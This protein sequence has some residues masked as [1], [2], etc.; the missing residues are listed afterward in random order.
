MYPLRLIVMGW[1]LTLVGLA[2]A[3]AE[4]VA[5]WLFD[6]PLDSPVAT[7]SSG[8][9]YHLTLGPDA[10]I[11]TGGQFGHAL[12]SDALRDQDGLGAFRYHAEE[13][14]N[15]GDRDWTLECWAKAR[16]DMKG[17]NRLWGLSGVNYIDYGRGDR[18]Q[19]LQVAS[20]FLPIDK[21]L[22]WDRPTGDL[23]ADGAFHHMAVVY[24]AMA[25]QLRHYFDGRLQFAVPGVWHAVDT[26][27]EPYRDV[28][29]PP[30][31]PMLQIGM[32]D[33]I[34]QWNHRELGEDTRLMKKFEG[35]LDE[36]RF[37]DEALYAADFTP[38][39]HFDQTCMRIW[40]ETLSLVVDEKGEIYGDTSLTLSYDQTS[41]LLSDISPE[42]IR[43]IKWETTSQ[44]I[45]LRRQARD[46]HS[47]AF[48]TTRLH[49]GLNLDE[50]DPG[51]HEG[52]IRINSK[53]FPN[54]PVDVSVIVRRL[55]SGDALDVR[56]R[57]Q[58]F[59][60]ERFI[61][62]SENVEL[63]VNPPQ[64]VEMVFE[65]WRDGPLV[66]CNIIHDAQRGVFRMYYVAFH[67][68]LS[69][70]YAES[71]DGLYWTAP[72]PDRKQVGIVSPD[73]PSRLLPLS[74]GLM[75]DP[76]DA[77]ERRYKVVQDVHDAEHP[78]RNGVYAY[79]SADGFQFKEAGRVLPILT[80]TGLYP[81]WDERIRKYVC[82]MRVM[83][84]KKGL[85]MIQGNQFFYRPGFTYES[86]EGLVDTIAPE[87]MVAE[88]Y[89]NIRSRARIET[90]DILKPWPFPQDV[91]DTVYTTPQHVPMVFHADKWDG[92]ADVYDGAPEI[93][94][95]AQD[96]YLM[97]VAMF[98]HFHPSR[99]PWF[100]R[101]ADA[102]GPIDV[103]LA[104]SRD[105]VHW[106]RWDRQPYVK[107]GMNDEWDRWLHFL[108]R[109]T[110]PIGNYLY[111]YYWTTGRLHDSLLL[112]PEVGEVSEGGPARHAIGALRQRLDGFISANADHRG[113]SLTTPPIKFSGD[114]LLL[115]HETAGMG[116]M[117]VEL[118]DPNDVPIPGY[119]LAD[120]EEITGNDVA[121]EVRWR[122]SGDVSGLAGRPLK[123]H[124]RMVSAKLYAFQFTPQTG[125]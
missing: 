9:G 100:Y 84:T 4:T 93:Y 53:G 108:G 89:E 40:P 64:K 109:G 23:Q 25:R 121:W 81:F 49:I 15:P 117:F 7:D 91:P 39:T 88:G 54:S 10:A 20:R 95:Y 82:Y 111:Q 41:S 31:Y 90:D 98:R 57:K 1:M 34:Q 113:G 44:W 72:G 94:P 22:G 55:A 79:Y 119:T 30:H 71:V 63:R 42:E 96:V 33:A 125:N 76:H 110:V 18:L 102:N 43:R 92:F 101:F 115:N 12:D 6:D 59:I 116:T 118:R 46:D 99:Q 80:E 17:D 58:L 120:C 60:D 69:L 78:E 67:K 85:R 5:L 86:P 38:P 74:G 65:P 66:P 16:P 11:V 114:R 73:D 21:V 97:Y 3:T 107:P 26:G 122:G 45:L 24:D 61:E 124:F 13:A 37:S 36:M 27:E 77:P 112:R 52:S 87:G 56:D 62:S 35:L 48:H 75:V 50:I 19:T 51:C 29:F 104:V 14:L 2:P 47:D 28:V 105:G 32:R 68:N 70:N 83:N 103:Q 8:N 123:I 106:K